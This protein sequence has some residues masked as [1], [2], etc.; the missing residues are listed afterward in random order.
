MANTQTH[1]LH[2]GAAEPRGSTRPRSRSRCWSRRACAAT[3]GSARYPDWLPWTQTQR[4]TIRPAHHLRV[5]RCQRDVDVDTS[6][7]ATRSLGRAVRRRARYVRSLRVR[8]LLR[9]L[10]V[11]LQ[12]TAARSGWSR[13]PIRPPESSSPCRASTATPA[14]GEPAP[15]LAAALAAGRLRVALGRPH[16]A[17]AAAPGTIQRQRAGRDPAGRPNLSA[18]GPLAPRPGPVARRQRSDRHRSAGPRRHRPFH[19]A[20]ASSPRSSASSTTNRRASTSASSVWTTE[21]R[22]RLPPGAELARRLPPA[23][24]RPRARLRP[25]AA[26]GL[27][28]PDQRSPRPASCASPGSSGGWSDPIPRPRS[29][30]RERPTCTPQ[31]GEQQLFAVAPVSCPGRAQWPGPARPAGPRQALVRCGPARRRRRSAQ[32][33]DACRQPRRSC[34]VQSD[35]TGT[36]T[37]STRRRPCHRCAPAACRCSPTPAR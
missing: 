34:P 31:L 22:A 18:M 14:S 33:A 15:T 35:V 17:G 1:H 27:R 10:R 16:R 23:A 30:P 24:A 28:G 20:Q 2:A 11:E 29:R 9:P 32:D 19:S 21:T 26:A 3:T 8:R 12:H 5:Q 25:R 7:S 37:S 4:S 6:A 36:P 13:R